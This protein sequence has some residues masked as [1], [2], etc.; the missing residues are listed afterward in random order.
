M[1]KVLSLLC[2]LFVLMPLHAFAH[3]K[4]TESSPAADTVVSES[5]EQITL[6]FNTTISSVSKFK[7]VNA[8]GEEQ[9][10]DSIAVQDQGMS[11]KVVTPLTDGNYTVQWNIIGEDGHAVEGS[12]NFEV[13]LAQAVEPT[14]SPETSETTEPTSS[15][16]VSPTTEPSSEPTPTASPQP[17]T[18][19]TDQSTG[20]QQAK[21]DSQPIWPYIIIGVIVVAVIVFAMRKR[22]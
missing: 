2:I 6:S 16:E 11:G 3:S 9:S 5:P 20:D 19:T 8:G 21:D 15:P 17:T 18:E 14:A 7:V 10:I 13:K 1:K 4:M 22:K 12:Y